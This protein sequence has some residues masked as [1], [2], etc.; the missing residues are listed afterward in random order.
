MPTPSLHWKQAPPDHR[1]PTE[2]AL[3]EATHGT[4]TLR[5]WH[6]TEADQWGW[7]IVEQTASGEQTETSAAASRPQAQREAEARARDRRLI[8]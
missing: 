3:F 1:S 6:S 8:P 4:T 7:A 5:V 2:A